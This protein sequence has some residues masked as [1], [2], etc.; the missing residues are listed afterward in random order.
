MTLLFCDGFGHIEDGYE[1]A[2]WD[3]TD[4]AGYMYYESGTGRD[5]GYGFRMT[6]GYVLQ[7]TFSDLTTIVIGSA[8]KFTD[9]NSTRAFLTLYDNSSIQVYLLISSNGTISV[10]RYNGNLLAS[11]SAGVIQSDTW[12]YIEFKTTIDNS[13]GIA[14]VKVNG[15]EVINESSLDTQYSA[16]ANVNMVQLLNNAG[17]STYFDDFYICDTSGTKNNDFLGD[18]NITTLYPNA[19]GTYSQFTPSSGSDHYALVDE[20]Q[21]TDDD[22][23]YTESATAGNKETFTFETFTGTTTI[24]AVQSCMAVKN[25]DAGTLNVQPVLISGASP[26]ETD[27]SNYLL[28]STT[29]CMMTI[30]EKEP[31]DDVDWTASKVN[32]AEFGLRIEP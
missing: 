13:S 21:L 4:N 14:I 27:G 19:D 23:D 20:A 12:Q 3:Y 29:K 5:G 16:S 8:V 18:I 6:I 9:L 1:L 15:V 25:T 24:L 2:K 26:T 30:Y 32:A 17:G 28:S 7:K 11:S 22:A 10:Y 31:I